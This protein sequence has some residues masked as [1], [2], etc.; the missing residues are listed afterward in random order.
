MTTARYTPRRRWAV[1][2]TPAQPNLPGVTYIPDTVGTYW[3]RRSADR[4]L[5]ILA[6]NPTFDHQVIPTDGAPHRHIRHAVLAQLYTHGPLSLRGIALRT[7]LYRA[8]VEHALLSA[9]RDGLV[10]HR[11]TDTDDDGTPMTS[12]TVGSRGVWRVTTYQERLNERNPHG[13]RPRTR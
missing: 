3:L 4:A 10:I 6:T 5:R 8:T 11:V 2:R 9:A 7:R 12:Y 13:H 1:V